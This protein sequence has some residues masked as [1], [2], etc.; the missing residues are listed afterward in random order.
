MS[1]EEGRV[2]SRRTGLLGPS[3]CKT[4]T[5][6]PRPLQVELFRDPRGQEHELRVHDIVRRVGTLANPGKRIKN[7]EPLTSSPTPFRKHKRSKE[8]RR[9]GSEK[10]GEARDLSHH[11]S[12]LLHTG[13][14]LPVSQPSPSHCLHCQEF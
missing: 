2:G 10:A 12:P 4:G 8:E 13:P 7:S 9:D 1:L 3:S 14:G 5:T 11:H 6:K